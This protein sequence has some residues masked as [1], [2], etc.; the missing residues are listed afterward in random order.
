MQGQVITFKIEGAKPKLIKSLW[1]AEFGLSI[2][3]QT[4]CLDII[5]SELT[6]H[7]EWKIN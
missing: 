4:L 3:N 5:T 7:I 2:P 6:T 1:N